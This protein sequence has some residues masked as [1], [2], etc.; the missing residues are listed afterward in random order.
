MVTLQARL[1]NATGCVQVGCPLVKAT[2][3]EHYDGAASLQL[4]LQGPFQ[5]KNASIAVELC[6]AFETHVCALR[7]E[8]SA[9]GLDSAAEARA[10][11]LG[12]GALPAAYA[13]GLAEC[14]LYG[15]AQIAVVTA[16]DMP[17]DLN[18]T[19]PPDERTHNGSSGAPAPVTFFLDGAHSPES[20]HVCADWFA[21][22]SAAAEGDLG[23]VSVDTVLLFNCG[24]TRKPALLLEPFAQCLKATGRTFRHAL[25]APADSSYPRSPRV[26][27]MPDVSWQLSIADAWEAL[28]AERG[29]AVAGQANGADDSPAILG[30]FLPTWA[31]Y[32]VRD[33][34]YNASCGRRGS[35]R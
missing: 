14:T 8:L 3:L 19:S 5:K 30:A 13:A 1:A 33:C 26:N 17:E 9:A 10:A 27:G 4:G 16:Q 34:A 18:D 12:A 2:A 15:R 6:R 23:D 29:G 24:D 22:A 25:F 20:C 21:G 31:S 32:N 11:E 28:E 35:G 7:P